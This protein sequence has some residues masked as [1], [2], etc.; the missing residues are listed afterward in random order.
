MS[1]NYINWENILKKSYGRK[2]AGRGGGGGHECIAIAIILPIL[3][4]VIVN[5]AS[6]NYFHTQSCLYLDRFELSHT[7]KAIGKALRLHRIPIN[8]NIGL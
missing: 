5:F 2:G 1:I 3:F 4:A 7:T 6:N 8:T